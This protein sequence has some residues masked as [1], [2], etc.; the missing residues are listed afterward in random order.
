MVS[1]S[2]VAGIAAVM[3]IFCLFIVSVLGIWSLNSKNKF[4]SFT[5]NRDT[6][7]TTVTGIASAF[8]I[9]V[10]K[11]K[12]NDSLSIHNSVG[13]TMISWIRH[14]S[15]NKYN[16]RVSTQ[17]CDFMTLLTTCV[18]KER[19]GHTQLLNPAN[20]SFLVCSAK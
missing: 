8:I 10:L 19:L 17:F 6:T 20:G 15:C 18:E 2:L 13:R 5:P 11:R 12:Q 3:G 16:L 14:L 9:G 7:L 4:D 1:N